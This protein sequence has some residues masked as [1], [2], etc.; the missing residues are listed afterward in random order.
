MFAAAPKVYPVGIPVLYAVILWENRE[1]LNPRIRTEPDG[2]VEASS[3]AGQVGEDDNPAATPS[4]NSKS[5][6]KTYSPEEL[7][8]LEEKVQARRVNPEL[9]P[10]MFL[11]KDFGERCKGNR[12]LKT[13]TFNVTH[14]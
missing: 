3:R 9:V 14:H 6:T 12:C 11:W 10:S 13:V 5:Q 1:L 8:E 4:T 2:A 7:Q